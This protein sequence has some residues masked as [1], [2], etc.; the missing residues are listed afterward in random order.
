VLRNETSSIGAEI[1]EVL[2]A[3][4]FQDRVSQILGHVAQDMGKLQERIATHDRARAAGESPVTVD[5]GAWLEELSHTYTVPE[6]HV[7]HGG[8]APVSA[9]ATETE[10]TFF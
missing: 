6:Q 8:G 9:A 2:V 1:S 4:Q 10:I 7:V 5:A 3:L